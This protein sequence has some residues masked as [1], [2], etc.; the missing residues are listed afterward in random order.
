M[1]DVYVMRAWEEMQHAQGKVVM[2]SDGNGELAASVGLVPCGEFFGVVRK[3]DVSS[4]CY[5][6]FFFLDV[7][8]SFSR[9]DYV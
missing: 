2:L 3:T 8:Q 4:V 1:N 6:V 5:S 9:H 7:E